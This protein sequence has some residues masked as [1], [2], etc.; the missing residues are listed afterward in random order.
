[1]A[2][3][4]KE[5]LRAGRGNWPIVVVGSFRSAAPAGAIEIF[6]RLSVQSSPWSLVKAY[7][8]HAD[9]VPPFTANRK[10]SPSPQQ[11]ELRRYHRSFFEDSCKGHIGGV[12]AEGGLTV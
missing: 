9:R 12:R 5:E 7:I 3:I 2:L 1:M 10:L 11:E 6:L 4:W 8:S